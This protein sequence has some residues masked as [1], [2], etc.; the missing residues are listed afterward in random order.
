MARMITD[1][2]SHTITRKQLRSLLVETTAIKGEASTGS[3]MEYTLTMLDGSPVFL[4][5]NDAAKIETEMIIRRVSEINIKNQ[6]DARL[7][8][9]DD[10]L[11]A[12][13][14][15]VEKHRDTL[16]VNRQ[17]LMQSRA[18]GDFSDPADAISFLDGSLGLLNSLM[19]NIGRRRAN[20]ANDLAGRN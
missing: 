3:A 8:G 6:K 12:V 20:I 7:R 18:A 4:I 19:A 17:A 15:M 10:A 13:L 14:Q 16:R 9:S 2:A 11:Y 1:N 5:V